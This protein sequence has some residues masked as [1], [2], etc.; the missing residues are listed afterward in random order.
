MIALKCSSDV[1]NLVKINLSISNIIM[2]P[3][4]GSGATTL[5]LTTHSITS[6]STMKLSME[7]CHAECDLCIVTL[8]LSVA[9]KPFMLSAIVLN[10][11]MLSV[12]A[13]LKHS[14]RTLHS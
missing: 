3:G 12:V 14:S 10:V 13:P 5:S 1:I 9:N 7:C 6:F 2:L 11:I 4:T 8:K